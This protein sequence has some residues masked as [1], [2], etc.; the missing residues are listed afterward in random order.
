MSTQ[1]T[2]EE[3]END[4]NNEGYFIILIPSEEKINFQGL[5]YK[6]KNMLEPSIIF[7]NR[8][9][10]NDETFLEEIV[11]KFKKKKKKKKKDEDDNE[12]ESSKSTKYEVKFFEEEHIYKITFSSK[13]DCFIYQPKLSIGNK[14][15][16]DIPQE[17]IQQNIVPLYV[18]L[19]IFLEALQ[20][21][22][23][24]NQKE[25]K[26]YS[27]TIDLYEEK[28]Q[29]SL[30]ITL[31]LKIYGKNKELC[32]K[33]IDIFYR[34]NHEENND[35]IDDLKKNLK[36][37]KDILSNA[38]EI[39]DENNYNS[40]HFYGVL[41]CYL[42][43]YDAN[44]FPK[45]IEEYFEGNANNLYEILICYYSHF[46]NPLK[47]SQKFFK[48][49][50][51]YALKAGKGQKIFERIMNYI[52]DIE[53]YVFIIDSYKEEIFKKYK[54]LRS[55]PLEMDASL[56]LLKH[57]EDKI[58]N[59]EHNNDSDISDE[60]D[61]KVLEEVVNIENEC[62]KIV[63]LIESI[64]NYAD[65]EKILAIYIRSSFWINLLEQY[66]FPD[67]ENISNC[68]NLRE[69]YKKYNNLVNKLYEDDDN[70]DIKNDIN[71]FFARDQFA[72]ILNNLIKEFLDKNQ[73]HLTNAE[74]LGCVRKFN[75]YFSIE[76][77]IYKSKRET[78][79]FDYVN[80][81][82]ITPAFNK[83]F[84]IF[85]FETMFEENITGYINKITEKIKDIQ[86]FGNIIKLINEKRMK[87]DNQES[88]IGILKEKYRSVI[89]D[90][91]E[92]I[93][94][95]KELKNGIKIIAE[96]V[97]KIFLF[98][99]K[100]DI[101]N[102]INTDKKNDKNNDKNNAFLKDE[103][104]S[105]EDNIKS[106]IYLE[107]ITSY[108]QEEY[109]DQKEFIYDIYLQYD[110]ISKKEGRD[111]VIKLVK[112]L[113]DNDRN[114][115]IYEKLLKACQFTK[116]EFFSNH[117]NYKIKLLCLLN[118]KLKEE[119]KNKLN[120]TEQ[121]ENGN[122]FA[123]SLA[124]VLDAVYKELFYGIITKRDLERFLN[125]KKVLK[126]ITN[127]TCNGKDPYNVSAQKN[128]KSEIDKYA[129]E[130][131]GLLSLV[132]GEDYVAEN[133]YFEYKGNID[134]INEKVA[135][136]ISTK[137][138]L[139]IF[140]RN[141][142]IDDIRKIAEIL[143]KINNSPMY[144]FK[145][146]ETSKSIDDLQQKYRDL[147]TQI[148]EVKDFLLFKKIFEK[149]QGKD[150]EALFKNAYTKLISLKGKFRENPK[151]IEAIINDK[152]Y[153]NIFKDIKEELGR[154]DEIKTDEF[155]KQMKKHFTI[156]DENAIDDIKMLIKSKKYEMIVNSIDYF[157][158]YIL[159]KDLNL[160]EKMRNLSNQPLTY[161]KSAL[162][163]L[164]KKD[165]YD[166]KSNSSY[167]RIFT[168]IYEKK[169]AIDFLLR[170]IKE[171]SDSKNFKN[172]ND[173]LQKKLDPTN[174]SITIKDISD[175]IYCL[176][177]VNKLLNKDIPDI[178]KYLKDLN[179]EDIK[180]FESFSKKFVS[181]IA[182][183]KKSEGDSFKEVYDIINEAT[184]LFHLDSEDLKY[185]IN[186]EDNKI[187]NINELTKFGNKINMQSQN[188]K[189]EKKEKD[190]FELKCHK[191]KFFKDLV[192]KT[193]II[194]DKINILRSKGYNLQI[195]IKIEIKYPEVT[196][197]LYGKPKDFNYIKEYLFNI[198]NEY[199]NQLSEIFES[200]KYIRF[201]YG[202]LLRKVSQHQKG[203]CK[204]SEI[205]RYILN[206]TKVNKGKKIV[207][208]T[209]EKHSPYIGEDYEKDYPEYMTTI[210]KSISEYLIDL[211]TVNEL[212][213]QKHYENM[214]IKEGN[215][216]GISII[217]CKEEKSMEENILSLF[218]KKL[219][220]L[221]IAQNILICSR[222]TTIEE[223]QSFLYRA[224]L[225]EFN[226]LFVLEI[227]DT[228]SNFQQNKMYSYIDKLTTIKMEKY[229][230]KN[231]DN[232]SKFLDKSNTSDYLDSYI[233]FIYK[234]LSNE[235]AFKNEL[236]NYM[237]YDKEDEEEEPPNYN[238]E[239]NKMGDLD[240][241]DISFSIIR[242]IKNDDIDD[243]DDIVN[244]ITV[245]SSD[246]CGLG[247]S[248]RIKKMIE[249]DGKYYYHFPLGG[250]L[251]KN[252][253]YQKI[254]DLFEKIKVNT[255]VE[256]DDNSEDNDDKK[257]INEEY[258]EFNNAAIHLD[259]V[260]TNEIDLINEFLFSFLIT[261]FYT[262]NENIIYIPSNIKIYIEVPNSTKDYLTKFGILNAFN[263]ENIILGDESQKI[264]SNTSNVKNVPMLPL[265]LEPK[266]KEKFQRINSK[267]GE[268]KEIEKFIRGNFEKIGIKNYSY[269]QIQTF[270]KLYIS[271][272]DS[273]E[274]ELKFY[275][276]KKEDITPQCIEHFAE[277]TKYFIDS[278]FANKLMNKDNMKDIFDLCEVAYNSNNS[279]ISKEKF[280]TPLIYV[281]KKNKTCEFEMLPDI[282][283]E[284]DK[285]ISNKDVDIVYLIDATGSMG[286]EIR[287]AK[288][289]V[290]KIFEKL[291]ESNK[292]Y[293]FRFGSVFYR[294]KIDS[295]SD[296]DEYFQ[297]TDNMKDLQE[298]IGKVVATG[299]GDL[300]EDWVGGYEIALNDMKWRE[301][302]IKLIIHIAD[303][304][305]HGIRFTKRDDKHDEEAKKLPPKIEECVRRNINIIG[306]KIS[307]E[308]KRSFDE[309]SKIYNNFKKDN[310]KY[311]NGQFI[312]IYEFFRD[313]ENQEVVS[314]NFNKLVMKAAKN[315]INPSYKYLKRLKKILDLDNDVEN[316]KGDK[317]S[318]LSLLNDNY[319]ITEDN[320][321]K[322][323]L[324]YYRIKANEPVII[325]GETGCG[326]T[327]LI[328]K[329]SQILNNG[330]DKFVEKIDIH[331]GITDEEIIKNMEKMNETAKSDKYKKKEL[332]IFFDEINT[333]LSL[334]LLTEIF[335]NR[336]FKGKKIEDNI[337]L[338][339]A[340]NPYRKRKEDAEICGLIR[341]DDEDDQSK[342]LDEDDQSKKL[343]YLVEQLPESL[344]YYVFSFASIS[345]EDE[346]KYIES[347]IQ[348]L[349]VKEEEKL[350]DL[351]TKAISKCHQFLR[352]FFGDPSI[353]SLREIARFTSC[354]EFF[355]E[356]FPIK[357]NENRIR[358]DD[359]TKKLYKIKSIIC[360]IY[361]CYYIRL[362]NET[363][364]KDFETKLLETL[365]DIVN[366]G[367]KNKNKKRV[368][369]GNLL[370]DIKYE[371]LREEL[372]DLKGKS[373][374]KFSDLLEIEEEFLFTQVNPDKGIGK[375]QSLKENLFLIFLGV[376]TEIPL[377]IVGK[378]G[379]GKSLSAQLV[380]NSMR[381]EYS[382]NS[383]FKNYPK[384]V[385]KYFQGSKNT[386]PE[387]VEELFKKSEELY[388]VY[389]GGKSSDVIEDSNNKKVPICMILFDELGLAEQSK[390]NPL[391]VLH[392]KLEYDGKKKG[393]CFIG[394]SNYSLDAAKVNRALSL[395][396]P[397]LEDKLD[398]LKQTADSIVKSIFSDDINS[399]NFLFNILAR[400]YYDYKHWLNFIKELTVLK[401]YLEDHK[402]KGTKDSKEIKRD[403]QTSSKQH[404]EDDK[405]IEKKD[406]KEIKRDEK[407]IKLLKKDRKIKTEFHGNRDFYSLIKGVAIEVSQLNKLEE[408]VIV[409]I[410]NHI[411]ERNFGGI[412][413]DIDIDFNFV[414]DDLKKD[415]G[416]LKG[417]ILNEK[418]EKKL[419]GN[420]ED[421]GDD[422][423]KEN[424][425][426]KVTSVF[427]F[428]KIYNEACSLEK[429]ETYQIKKHNLVKYDLNECINN[430]INDN[431]SRYL[432]L[433]IRSNLAPL[434]N[435]IIRLQNSERND[436][437][438][439]LIGSPFSDFNN[440]DYKAQK[441]NEIQ[442][443]ASQKYKL[444]ILQNLDQILAYLYDL[445]NMN[446]K[447]ID[448]Q[449]FVRICLDNFSEQLT[450]VSESFKI[451]VLVDKKFV[452][453][454]DMAFLNRLEKMQI[455]FQD[456][457]DRDKEKNKNNNLKKLIE[458][459]NGEIKL[460]EIIKKKK[461]RE[462]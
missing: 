291:T 173:Q 15:L 133:K 233:V 414:L 322:M 190:I 177:H 196:Y 312:E 270:I 138:S 24:L 396:V 204:I 379:T 429:Q 189:E 114:I 445:F 109:K 440:S 191:L 8:V 428:K 450:P 314:N 432:L 130:K 298:K 223:M 156:T 175:M 32:K 263:R 140:H 65:K 435:K 422:K 210:F 408:N 26:L 73:Q 161:L 400:A 334:S 122:K 136:L 317:K 355:Q 98:N 247:K 246:V 87:E 417:K 258:T 404:S 319:V 357:N 225:C 91:I 436:N 55:N 149:A 86:T 220:K 427:L 72:I 243:I 296:K 431:N 159:N 311:E 271:Q 308:P 455:S 30:L 415:L 89:K 59:G 416:I 44:N 351:T 303:A 323:V 56:K 235:S 238:D 155:L 342:K 111:N 28:K 249:F 345:E 99:K 33:L 184:F 71:A 157:F 2:K 93:K 310:Y 171:S 307:D 94:N 11:F 398:Q 273:F 347:I 452:N 286:R 439:T 231:K 75:P 281:D 352:Q 394:I 117:E 343:V 31:F 60:D 217:K 54:E 338:M 277:S 151:N 401:Q 255:N 162:E 178:I 176:K 216:K 192:S 251:T 304:G 349:F 305:A 361:I 92:L 424:N 41:F 325:M 118:E 95:D 77:N 141:I 58:T 27:D 48:S 261:K 186:G 63:K 234:K 46:I 214:I 52:E 293:N 37:F 462:I 454:I 101:N 53:T 335:R 166:Y 387:D 183:D 313:K 297:F 299:G 137:D 275:N 120:I 201:L 61:D 423:E 206:K 112:N 326:K 187:S 302:G 222:E 329:L 14:Y 135:L 372:V 110:K 309:I 269:N 242:S 108:N 105:L 340:C 230:Q 318:L 67:W 64:I 10:K 397:N 365:L 360:S 81:S 287:A 282:A 25:E 69:L 245:I 266:I 327:S 100:N 240:I 283:K 142:Y 448:D 199:E 49:F 40:V 19:N 389:G 449:R 36:S 193:E 103:I 350:H 409:R 147:C 21:A 168:S 373:F 132:L 459:I 97:S 107:L 383:F 3:E 420:N 1:D 83:A 167:Y 211:F 257:E 430:N 115:F 205:I 315:V 179:E 301:N 267:I 284:K 390:T 5:S 51:D 447:L 446:Y 150:Q 381:G 50:I 4:K 121:S 368:K 384:I 461:K 20:K 172:L 330:D 460:K 145:N 16:Q 180:K 250:K 129:M 218:A 131:L 353:V 126:N 399:N 419:D 332:W 169:E 402:K 113:K 164:S 386:N 378:P 123:K 457:L 375:N 85:N 185:K 348:K 212:D 248:F 406:F 259:I 433:E 47:Q 385:Q 331:P 182:L 418:L 7:K 253:I 451:I 198:T 79:I 208:D 341:E 12:N 146:N 324:L 371:K 453:K 374:E 35:K 377:I 244:N 264:T 226:T 219:Y 139:M 232:K 82:K 285:L 256:N 229:K 393:T 262:N 195:E 254:L 158:R 290:I 444:I 239:E 363:K 388:K 154:K 356:Y 9:E 43:F 458:T 29:F 382:K 391:K 203:H 188:K 148:D 160:P 316:E 421:D 6:A 295:P 119:S 144:T 367:D 215:K 434:I 337:R 13:S 288:D 407:F 441:I 39:I 403:E 76:E 265:E 88:Y 425:K 405:N 395:S 437:I 102:D 197:E 202:K 292:G 354:V 17:P 128:D 376:V 22:N 228:F 346:K 163:E 68:H 328:K 80:F 392:N 237:I 66:K 104:G 306:F 62:H 84:K 221:P 276:S 438:D 369:S 90:N 412:T 380:Y 209:D 241:S 339:G 213:F 274:G 442:N 127:E 152:D 194:F 260:E 200:D 336:T 227:L 153:E 366:Y 456:L 236:N 344:L 321:K 333:C 268:D 272:F 96:F 125:I 38:H 252:I 411:I 320:Y 181:I 143:D 78:Y 23:E 278:G 426:I 34:I 410:I 289:N 165:Y 362:T 294:D 207:K 42:H 170:K 45:I 116:D 74:K 174:R 18:K 57:K 224:I 359:E 358:L 413:Y 280:N 124:S 279:D 134:N 300:P 70:N 443:F 370:D 364:R 106:L